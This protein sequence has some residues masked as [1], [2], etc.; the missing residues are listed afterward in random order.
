MIFKDPDR[1]DLNVWKPDLSEWQHLTA[2]WLRIPLNGL[3]VPDNY[4]DADMIIGPLS[5]KQSEAKAKKHFPD[6]GEELQLV[7]TS[8]EGCKRLAASLAAIIYFTS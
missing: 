8:Y 1:R 4:K 5:V 6:Q 7:C 2:H 3:K